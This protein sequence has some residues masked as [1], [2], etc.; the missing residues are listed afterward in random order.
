MRAIGWIGFTF[1]VA[2]RAAAAQVPVEWRDS[3]VFH[4][5]SIAAIDPRTGEV[6]AA[7]TTRVPCVGNGVPWVRVGVG[8]VATQANTRTE[9]GNELLDALAKGEAPTD[10]LK[11]LLAADSGAASRQ[12]GVIDMKGR[13][14]QYTGTG[15]QDWKGNRAGKNYV[16][17]GN[18]LVGPQ[19]LEA[20]AKSFEAS[21]GQ[22]RHLADRLID[23]IAAGHA[24]GGDQRHGLRQSAAVIVADPRPG[25][26]RRTDGV[27]A[28]ISVCENP[29]PVAE[30]RRIYDAI[31]QTLGYRTLQQFSGGDVWQLKVMLQALGF[32]HANE[33]ALDSRAAGANVFSPDVGTAVDAFRASEKLGGPAVGSPSGL[34]DP[35]TVA[36][37]WSALER[38]G[39]A[40]A[41]RE[42]LL[43]AT[44]VRR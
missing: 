10:A 12:I 20:V 16:T 4:T 25:R 26:S 18:V 22:P 3:L 6:G 14:A 39:K 41:V 42:Q 40:R 33:P 44:A 17:Q 13:S 8:A 2:A 32:Y 21:E 7:V 15:P 11:R 27:T 35:E 23:A 34:V 36:H 1:V 24:Q 5:F 9:Y 19:V 37:L 38:A 31:S 43:D 30:M 29:E 28:N